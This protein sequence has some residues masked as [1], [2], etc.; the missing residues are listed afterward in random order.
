MFPI[1]SNNSLIDATGRSL[2]GGI[3]K[4]FRYTGNSPVYT[5]CR[6]KPNGT[7][8][9]VEDVISAN[10]ICSVCPNVTGMAILGTSLSSTHIEYI[11]D[12]V[13]VIVALD[14]DATHKTLEYRREIASWTGVD[15][16]AMRLQDDIKYRKLE[17]LT[18]LKILCG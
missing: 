16:I 9:I 14:P 17:D 15:T 3:P 13:R 18:K 11:Q 6:G 12:F 8:V 1:R 7:V 2:D 5:A 10:T 4:W